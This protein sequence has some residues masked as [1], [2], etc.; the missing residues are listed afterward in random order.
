M[1][2]PLRWYLPD[3]VYE[4]TTRTTQERYLLRPGPIER[5]VILGIL[6]RAL[7]FYQCVR[8]HAF[9]YLSNHMH[10][11]L[12]ALDASQ[13]APFIGY[14]NGNVAKRIGAR[15]GWSD[16]FWASRAHV[17]PV[18]D[19]ESA[20]GRLRYILSHGVK[21]GLVSRPEEWPGASSTP[22]LLGEPLIGRWATSKRTPR[23]EPASQP[24]DDESAYPVT[25]T[26]LP[27]WA[28]L[29]PAERVARA[30]AL[31][32][33]IESEYRA[34][35]DAPVLGVAEVLATSPLARPDDPARR[36]A[37]SCH[38][39]TPGLRAAFYNARLMFRT[40]YRAAARANEGEHVEYRGGFP[41]GSYGGRRKFVAITTCVAP[42]LE[43]DIAAS[44]G[45]T[46]HSDGTGGEQ[47]YR[48]DA[49]ALTTTRARRPRAPRQRE[50]SRPQPQLPPSCGDVAVDARS[51]PPP[52]KRPP[53]RDRAPVSSA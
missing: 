14:V 2:H 30:R 26:P 42:W 44:W 48:R 28:R 47:V 10:M 32:D 35:R 40:V 8:L 31:C 18:L 43:H 34:R 22:A 21:E 17:I 50:Q 23:L 37:P 41:P 27:T 52:R 25:I 19:D 1:G 15:H 9:V 51:P 5:V 12:S 7:A 16:H 33:S 24:R 38:V 36:P 46:G 4:V 45:S 29:P 49:A 53:K 3:V 6:G 13:L 39:A 20:E 11:L